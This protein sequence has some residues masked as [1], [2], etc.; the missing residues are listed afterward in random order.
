VQGGGWGTGRQ[1]RLVGRVDLLHGREGRRIGRVGSALLGLAQ[2]FFSCQ[3]YC[4]QV[5]S[6]GPAPCILGYVLHPSQC[7]Y[8]SAVPPMCLSMAG[9]DQAMAGLLRF[10][11][12]YLSHLQSMI[13]M[14][15]LQLVLHC[16]K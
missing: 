10:C 6:A 9:A 8:A 12:A 15:A 11:P 3:L 14:L 5:H 1:L 2:P 7:G 16:W 4:L 13:G